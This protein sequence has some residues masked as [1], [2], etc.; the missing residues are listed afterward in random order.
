[1][2]NKL[3][4]KLCAAVIL[5]L[6]SISLDAQQAP[7]DGMSA[8][9]TG[10]PETVESPQKAFLTL[11]INGTAVTGLF[12]AEHFSDGRVILVESAWRASN[13][14]IPEKKLLMGYGQWGYDITSL[15]GVIY[16]LDTASQSI[17]VQLQSNAFALTELTKSGTLNDAPEASPLGGYVNYSLSA[18]IG[19][20]GSKSYGALIE[21][22]VFNQLGAVVS[23]A[24][25]SAS[26]GQNTI[27]RGDTYFQ[28]DMPG[29]MVKVIIGDSTTSAGAWSRPIRFGG[30]QWSTDFSLK[31]GFISV[32][33]PSIDGSAALPST[34]D[35]FI[36]NQKSQSNSVT[37]GPFQISNLPTSFN[38][39][40]EINVV[41][42]DILGVETI[43]TQRF[44]STARLL[45]QG[46]N[47]FSFEAGMERKYYGIE[48]NNYNNPF[49]AGTYRRGFD[50]Y[51][52]EGHT[53]IQKTRQAVGIDVAGVIKQYAVIYFALA[54]SN[55]HGQA[56][57]HGIAGIEHSSKTVNANLRIEYYDRDFVQMGASVSDIGPRRKI[58]AGLGLNFYKNLWI[59]TNVISQARWNSD[60]FNVVSSSLAIPLT[61][62]IRLSAYATKQFGQEHSY[63]V[64][65]NISVPFGKTGMVA[66]GSTQDR[67]GEIGNNIRLSQAIGK[68]IDYQVS[69]SD[70]ADRPVSITINAA[71]SVNSSSLTL[72]QSGSGRAYRLRTNGSVGLLGGLPFASKQIGLGSFAVIKVANEPNIDIYQ[73]NIKVARTNSNGLAMLPN[74]VAYQQN[75][76]SVNPEDI[77]FDM[78][79]NETS[80]LVTPFARSGV[81]IQLDIK[82]SNNRLVRILKVDGSPVPI[83]SKV[84]L[85]PRNTY[86]LVARRGQ[87]YLTEL[88]ANNTLQVTLQED[89][90]NANLSTPINS[91]DTHKILTVVCK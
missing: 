81:F 59:N 70:S 56:A 11:E 29:N 10:T 42:K 54:A 16:E 35:V 33:T 49:I 6:A 87:V 75:K 39:V 38:G 45:K 3:L 20:Q 82:R 72:A 69:G 22:V 12:Y 86:F 91:A 52:V 55:T 67:Q 2:A 48:N 80:R 1:M 89:T 8:Q 68:G 24:V 15:P 43:S 31:R 61:K 9:I 26:N 85:L 64:G 28:K 60:T 21:G 62:D 50:G 79:V 57:L 51:T 73:S 7:S 88:S 90:C 58:M 77:P 34:I 25:T 47:E 30:I 78:Q 14:N 36:D 65:L 32:L 76:I 74:M 84:H 27:F 83:G 41:V 18:T 53:E 13:L 44:Y 19:Q 63:T 40:G 23:S 71:T 37:A 17:V 4:I 66:M 5:L 46:L